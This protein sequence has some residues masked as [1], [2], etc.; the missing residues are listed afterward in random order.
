M[1][2]VLDAIARGGRDR[3]RVIAAGLALGRALPTTRVA[4][5]R[6][7]SNGHF[8]RVAARFSSR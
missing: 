7:G 8:R 2:L 4:I 6:P 1:T 3:R 5:Y